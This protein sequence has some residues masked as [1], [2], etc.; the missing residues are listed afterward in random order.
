VTQ[1]ATLAALQDAEESLPTSLALL[2]VHLQ[3]QS[4]H[5]ILV[6]LLVV[7]LASQIVEMALLLGLK[8]AMLEFLQ[9]VWQDAEEQQPTFPVQLEAL[10]PPLYAHANQGML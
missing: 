8:S 6:T 5:A 1:E 4:V 10:L 7:L 9:D 3:L 2:G